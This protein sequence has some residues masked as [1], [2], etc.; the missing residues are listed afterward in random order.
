M[1]PQRPATVDSHAR[2]QA[3]EIFV[4]HVPLLDTQRSLKRPSQRRLSELLG[5]D[6]D[7]VRAARVN[8]LF[9]GPDDVTRDIVDALSPCF[10]LPMIVGHPGDPL[11]L[12]PIAQAQTMILH[13]IGAFGLADQ[14][15][16]LEWLNG[17]GGLT[18][19]ITTTS[20]PILPLLN[21]GAFLDTLYYRLN[22]LYFEVTARARRS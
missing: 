12:A 10:R 1:A 3:N 6:A 4:A 7:L 9:V 8:L 20:R 19:V 16:L 17:A 5:D 22:S 15:R 13:D 21:P 18:Q 14:R 2:R 11:V